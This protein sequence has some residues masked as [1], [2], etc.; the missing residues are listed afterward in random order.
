M[1]RSIAS[2]AL[3]L[4]AGLALM[5]MPAP[6]KAQYG[7]NGGG[8]AIQTP[9]FSLGIGQVYQPYPVVVPGYPVYRPYPSYYAPRAVPHWSPGRGYHID[10]VVPGYGPVHNPGHN[11]PGH[12][13]SYGPY[14]HY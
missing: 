6:A 1:I 2:P 3:G 5:A 8:L 12:H 13:N 7:P 14:R 10:P 4:V 11:H 9:N